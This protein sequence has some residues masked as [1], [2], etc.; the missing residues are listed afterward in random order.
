MG[1]ST[2]TVA[3]NHPVRTITLNR[4][5][6]RNAMTAGMQMELIAAMEAAATSDAR[7]LVLAGTGDAFCSGLDLS[8]LKG[9]QNKTAADFHTDA[10]RITRRLHAG[11]TRGKIW[12]HR[13]AHRLCACRRVCFPRL[14]D[15]R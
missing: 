4:P 5:E 14:A 7:V 2:I 13:G 9:M 6:R 10:E 15:R 11:D 1:Y 8:E 3:D 12:L